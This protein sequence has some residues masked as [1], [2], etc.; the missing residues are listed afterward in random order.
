M[1]KSKFVMLDR[2]EIMRAEELEM[3]VKYSNPADEKSDDDLVYVVLTARS[4]SALF[5]FLRDISDFRDYTD[6]QVREYYMEKK[7]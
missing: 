5:E 4:D 6:A 7:G 2:R 1:V 3:T